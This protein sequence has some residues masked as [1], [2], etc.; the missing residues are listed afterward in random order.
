MALLTEAQML[1]PWRTGFAIALIGPP[2]SG[3]T[4][5][6]WTMWKVF[7]KNKQPND[8]IEVFDLDGN[9]I[10]LA[11]KAQETGNLHR[12]KIHRVR[13][14]AGQKV[15][16]RDDD[17]VSGMTPIRSSDEWFEFIN[18][19]NSLYDQV[20]S[21]TGEWKNPEHA[22]GLIVVD[23]MSALQDMAFSAILNKRNKEVGVANRRVE[24]DEWNLLRG[25]LTEVI[26]AAKGLPCYSAFP[27]HLDYRQEEAGK[28]VRADKDGRT[29][30]VPIY[31]DGSYHH[32]PMIVGQLAFSILKE[33][34]CSLETIYRNGKYQWKVVPDDRSTSLGSRLHDKFKD[35]YL[36]QDFGLIL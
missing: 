14:K 33:F 21:V 32:V 6:L 29:Q 12:L 3:K 2:F 7:D 31:V 30:L 4:E 17:G 20:N 9:A 25:K 5:S 15:N 22:P 18:E 24:F 13:R 11:R 1:E 28:E 10:V 36:D 34:G 35:Q 16:T 23:S 27:F 19:F 8:T 26:K